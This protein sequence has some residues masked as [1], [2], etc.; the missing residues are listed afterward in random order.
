MLHA[1]HNAR[2]S[3]QL[4]TLVGAGVTHA[5]ML[6]PISCAG[7]RSRRRLCGPLLS[8]RLR[9]R[10]ARAESEGRIV[11]LPPPMRMGERGAC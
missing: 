3:L 5:G 1:H 2:Y 9:Q 8:R 10:R 4:G 11:I 7:G 6:R